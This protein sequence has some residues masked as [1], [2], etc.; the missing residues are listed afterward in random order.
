MEERVRQVSCCSAGGVMLEFVLSLVFSLLSPSFF[1]FGPSRIVE[2][3]DGAG[4]T[5]ARGVLKYFHESVTVRMYFLFFPA[6]V[7]YSIFTQRHAGGPACLWL[8]MHTYTRAH[9][10]SS[11]SINLEYLGYRE[12]ESVYYGWVGGCQCRAC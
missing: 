9:G 10:R 8:G 2:Q 6:V 4:L 1:A 5:V 12:H 3:G 11:S 7:L